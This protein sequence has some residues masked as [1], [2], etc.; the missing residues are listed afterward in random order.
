MAP[1]GS[2]R[3]PERVTTFVGREDE[4]ATVRAALT[5]SKLVT[6]TRPGGVGKTSV[7]VQVATALRRFFDDGAFFV[8]LSSATGAAVEDAVVKAVERTR[9]R[10]RSGSRP[11]TVWPSF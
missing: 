10:R 3:L 1:T 8:D 4:I 11:G 2:P 9:Q 5:A 6:L 7:A